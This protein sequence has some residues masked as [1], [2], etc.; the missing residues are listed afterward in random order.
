[1][2]TIIKGFS[3]KLIQSLRLR[4]R[5]VHPSRGERSIFFLLLFLLLWAI[6][7]TLIIIW[8][9]YMYIWITYIILIFLP[10]KPSCSSITWR[11][12]EHICCCGLIPLLRLKSDPS[13]F[14]LMTL[15]ISV[16][17]NIPQILSLKESL[18][19][20]RRIWHGTSCGNPLICVG[21]TNQQKIP[22]SKSCHSREGDIENVFTNFLYILNILIPQRQ[23]SPLL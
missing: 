2:S 9:N 3:A 19:G 6:L 10:Q 7:D 4:G 8:F 17:I 12:A 20:K 1:M 23:V 11:E 21:K 16:N 15:N 18:P 14:K 13:M 5:L 22:S